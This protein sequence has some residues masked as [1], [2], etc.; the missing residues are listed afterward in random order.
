MIY[1]FQVTQEDRKEC[2]YQTNWKHLDSNLKAIRQRPY[3]Y[4]QLLKERPWY[5]EGRQKLSDTLDNY[6][7]REYSLYDWQKNHC[8]NIKNWCERQLLA[9]KG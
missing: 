7:H 1:A 8:T 9:A 2:E 5:M 6:S 4:L 3:N